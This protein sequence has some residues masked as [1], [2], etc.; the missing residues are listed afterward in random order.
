MEIGS[1]GIVVA[2]KWSRNLNIWKLALAGLL[3]LAS[4]FETSGL[5]LGWV[6]AWGDT[7]KCP[8]KVKG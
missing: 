3:V 4:G 1:V 2:L 5:V 8:V 6:G 7:V